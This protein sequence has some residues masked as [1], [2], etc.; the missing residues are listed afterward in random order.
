MDDIGELIGIAAI[1]AAFVACMFVLYG[2][3]ALLDGVAKE[4]DARWHHI[5]A[6]K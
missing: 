4:H 1:F 6:T 3:F 2:I 5:E